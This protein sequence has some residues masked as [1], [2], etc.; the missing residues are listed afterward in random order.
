MRYGRNL[1]AYRHFRG[2][3]FRP[4]AIN[5]T[6]ITL[7]KFHNTTLLIHKFVATSLL[8]PQQISCLCPE[9]FVSYMH[10]PKTT[11]YA[12]PIFLIS[13]FRWVLNIVCI[14]LGI[15][16]VSVSVLPMFRNPLLVPSSRAGSIYSQP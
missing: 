14:L 7:L 10:Q 13:G 4:N 8:S 2:R 11:F 6:L 16:P 1:P 9:M 5:P 12:V 3:C 15:S